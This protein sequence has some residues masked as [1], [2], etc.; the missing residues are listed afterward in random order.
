VA[1]IVLRLLL[2]QTPD[3]AELSCAARHWQVKLREKLLAKPFFSL[4]CPLLVEAHSFRSGSAGF[5]LCENVTQYIFGLFS[6]DAE[7]GRTH[8]PAK[9]LN[10]V[11]GS[12][13]RKTKTLPL[14]TLTQVICADKSVH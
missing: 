11:V 5:S 3:Q 8:H 7:S 14:M 10:R 9:R 2:S 1:H 13:H 4:L 12:S 6:P